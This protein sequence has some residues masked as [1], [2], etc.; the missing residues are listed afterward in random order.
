MAFNH[1][2]DLTIYEVLITNNVSSR[3]SGGPL[4]D[5]EGK[6]VGMVSWGINDDEG[7]YNGAK[8]LDVFC[9]KILKCEYEYDG[10]KTWFE[11]GD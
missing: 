2:L 1:V 5:N 11:Y 4:I 10:E 8:M 3:N 9:V 7:Q 6:V